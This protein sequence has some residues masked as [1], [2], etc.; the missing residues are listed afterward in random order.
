MTTE[1]T[2]DGPELGPQKY[3]FQIENWLAPLLEKIQLGQKVISLRGMWGA[4]RGLLIAALHI[5]Q[6]RPVL[7]I[8]PSSVEGNALFQDIN[9]FHKLLLP[10]REI[11]RGDSSLPLYFP[12]WEI[13]AYEP[14][15]PLPEISAK[16]L[17]VLYKLLIGGDDPLVVTPIAAFLQR[18]ISRQVL[19]NTAELLG[20][21]EEIEREKIIELLCQGGYR[22]VDMV[23]GCEEYSV[24]GGIIDFFGPGLKNPVRIEFFG[25]EIISL[26]SFDYETQR[27]LAELEEVVI[28]P[29]HEAVL[30][31][32]TIE[33]L[34]QNV[35]HKAEDSPSLHAEL[36]NRL[37][38]GHHFAGVEQYIPYIYEK[39]ALLLD[40]MPNDPLIVLDEPEYIEK[41][42]IDFEHRVKQ[43]YHQIG[44]TPYPS[45]DESYLS[46]EQS[47][48]LLA[49]KTKINLSS[50]PISDRKLASRAMKYDVKTLELMKIQMHSR[51]EKGF[52]GKLAEKIRHRM[53]RG[54]RVLIVCSTEGQAQRMQEV[55]LDYDLLASLIHSVSNGTEFEQDRL[56]V[57]VGELTAGFRIPAISL[58]IIG[59][60]DIFGEP[61][62]PRQRKR[63]RSS[64]FL[65]NF[66]DLQVGDYV[67]HVDHG[68]GRYIG[69]SKL[70]VDSRIVDFLLLEYQDADKLYVPLDRLY[71]VQKYMGGDEE[72]VELHK[73]GGRKWARQKENVKANL[74]Q[75]ADELLKTY[76]AREVLGGF[77][78]NPDSHWQKEFEASFEYTETPD[79]MKV[80]EEVKADMEQEKPMDRLVCGDVGYGKTE[81][82]LRAA[83]KAVMSGKQVAILVPTTI[84]AQQHYNNFLQRL[85]PYPFKV[86]MLSRFKTAKE[87][88]QVI[89][90]LKDGTIDIVV[91]TH[92]LLQK[93]IQFANLGLLVID[94]EQ[95]FGV[96]HKEKIKALR[97]QVDV[98]TMT[99]TPIPRTLHFALSGMRDL[100]IIDTPPEGRL[101]IHTEVIAFDRMVVREA[102]LRE[103]GR[104]G[105]VFFVTNR[106]ENIEQLAKML[107]ELVPEARITVAHGQMH[108]K[109]LETIMINFMQGKYDV[110][111]ST[112]IIESGLDVSNANTIIIN[113]ADT[114]GLAQLYQLRGRV[115]R[116]EHRAYAY[117]LTPPGRTLTEGA[118]KRLKAIQELSELGAGFRLAAHDL[119]I[120][121]GG[122]VLGPQQHGHINIIGFDLYCQMLEEAVEEL[123]GLPAEKLVEPVLELNLNARLS[124]EYI[125]DTN[126]RLTF[127]KRLST[128]ES[129]EELG[130]LREEIV[131]RYG[132]MPPEAELLLQ[133]MALKVLARSLGIVKVQ[134]EGGNYRISF[135]E[136][137]SVS[138]QRIVTLI[139]N[140][141][142]RLALVPDNQLLVRQISQNEDNVCNEVKDIFLQLD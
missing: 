119:E 29:A 93:G 7:V 3:P 74:L 22:E 85:A 89:A 142:K 102:I 84:L 90:G 11:G 34:K 124:E 52:L 13:L 91:G 24:R 44:K 46:W 132:K 51:E 57:T 72:K 77:S 70:Q 39:T 41:Q 117:L 48:R 32:Q 136:Q 31:P 62:K 94:E 38:L 37:E 126:Q 21:G 27:S 80:I 110:L 98:L 30:T 100:S 107:R 36:L 87:K 92:S 121:G 120:R 12:P 10:N 61:K 54:E 109:M 47:K 112:T 83:F 115:G 18:I 9:F 137:T 64:R 99:A 16:R 63:Y 60:S 66:S 15:S 71:L 67:V 111:V 4:S 42:G 95:H 23:E 76:A 118:R 49:K 88:I 79:Q 131:D 128:V 25:D 141:P 65:S 1:T 116:S 114:F 6:E 86:D 43:E 129:E 105:Q 56:I 106:V 101:D 17:N 108:E 69:L 122:N 97:Q 28:L 19:G 5:L 35:R 138:P 26:R 40:Y 2:P 81:V 134:R 45:P 75:M 8:T 14:L 33:C 135:S 59:E 123:K 53:K 125:P 78:F 113:R 130:R 58:V 139:Q 133:V 50:L 127:Y 140:D 68:I 82:A 55:L 104:D 20:V 73:L 103:M 96:R